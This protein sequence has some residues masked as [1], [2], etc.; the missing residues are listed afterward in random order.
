MSGNFI[1]IPQNILVLYTNL[2]YSKFMHF[3][4]I[5]NPKSANEKVLVNPFQNIFFYPS[6][7]YKIHISLTHFFFITPLKGPLWK[8]GCIDLFNAIPVPLINFD[9]IVIHT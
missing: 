7:L 3:V 8:Q 6:F 5:E 1:L 9:G 4:I 2:I